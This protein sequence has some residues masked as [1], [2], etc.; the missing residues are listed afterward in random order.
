MPARTRSFKGFPEKS[1][2]PICGTNEDAPCRLIP[3]A[4]TQD[5][6]IM[7]A[8]PFHVAC[9]EDLHGLQWLRED[10]ILYTRQADCVQEEAP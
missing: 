3:I 9:L 2:C 10:G 7:E 4:G 5:D 6:G 1:L 8:Q